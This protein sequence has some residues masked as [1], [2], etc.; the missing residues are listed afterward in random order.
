SGQVVN[1]VLADCLPHHLYL[2]ASCS[3]RGDTSRCTIPKRCPPCRRVH[4]HSSRTISPAQY[5]HNRRHQY[6]SLE[7]F[8]ARCWPS[9]SRWAEIHRP[10]RMS[11]PTTRRAQQIQTRLQLANVFPPIS[12]KLP[13]LDKRS[14]T[15][16]N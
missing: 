4:N 6:P 7:I 1:Q 15:P 8:P 11:F 2:P 12:R 14:V 9:I 13:R 5:L 3:S 10:T 16:D